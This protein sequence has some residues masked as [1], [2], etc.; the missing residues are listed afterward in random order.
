MCSLRGSKQSLYKSSKNIIRYIRYRMAVRF[1]AKTADDYSMMDM[2]TAGSHT[3]RS[4]EE[5]SGDIEDFLLRFAL[6]PSCNSKNQSVEEDAQLFDFTSDAEITQAIHEIVENEQEYS[7][8]Y[9]RC[10][11]VWLRVATLSQAKHLMW[12]VDPNEY[13]D[14][15]SVIRRQLSFSRVAYKLIRKSYGADSG[16]H[17][18]SSTAEDAAPVIEHTDVGNGTSAIA[19]TT[20][21]DEPYTISAVAAS[22]YRDM[23]QVLLNCFAFNTEA[24]A[25]TGHAQK[26][27]QILHRHMTQ[28]IFNPS[29]PP[30][31]ACDDA[32]CLLSN[33]PIAVNSS[34]YTSIKCGRCNGVFSLSALESH[35]KELG[36]VIPTQEQLQSSQAEDWI[37]PLCLQEDSLATEGHDGRER[38]VFSLDEWGPSALVPWQ[39]NERHSAL[40]ESTALISPR[41]RYMVEALRVLS[42]PNITPVVLSEQRHL[43]RSAWAEQIQVPWTMNDRLNVF[44]ALCEVLKGHSESNT[45]LNG[46]YNECVKLSKMSIREP[47]H[48]ADFID[49]VRKIA[50]NDGA[51]LCLRLMDGMDIE[52]A[53]E[54]VQVNQVI[55]GRCLMCRGSTFEDDYEG[56]ILLCDGCNGEAHFTCLDLEKVPLIN[57]YV[58]LLYNMYLIRFPVRNGFVSHARSVCLIATKMMEAVWRPRSRTWTRTAAK[59]R[60][61]ASW[62]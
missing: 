14:Y 19:A 4:A 23:R 56:T 41:V 2:T 15:A 32:H 52:A 1:F 5:L 46:I 12:D 62:M 47:F 49:Q 25:V 43:T 28:W 31:S 44:A 29:A 8:D 9:R 36:T 17:T 50:G 61:F 58:L 38:G 6:Q 35:R 37:C 16:T 60:N 13:P 30:I 24:I 18:S 26:L 51:T 7:E 20:H 53:Q 21:G 55:D 48:E 34:E 27:T 45:Y 39:F 40:V 10:C 22:F 33:E 3:G 57:I 54:R 59:M 11:K 42:S